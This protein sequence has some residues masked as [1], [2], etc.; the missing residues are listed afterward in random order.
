MEHE[1]YFKL[2]LKQDSFAPFMVWTSDDNR[3]F[4]FCITDRED[5]AKI[6][7]TLNGG[8]NHK[9]SNKVTYKDGDVFLDGEKAFFIRSWGRLI[10]VGGHNLSTTDAAKV[11][12]SFGEWM[13]SKLQ[14]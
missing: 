3:A 11:Q 8:R 12:D 14:G 2:P 9:I 10:G 7:E 6:I 5:M 1:K 13:V 4:D